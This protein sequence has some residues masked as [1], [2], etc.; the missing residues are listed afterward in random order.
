M[1]EHGF[2]FHSP[3][4]AH[5][6]INSSAMINELIAPFDS[7]MVV[8][9]K[10]AIVK[11]GFRHFIEENDDKNIIFFDSVEENPQINTIIK[12]AKE[13]RKNKCKAV[14]GFGGGSALDAAKA[15]AAFA[16]NNKSFYELFNR[17][18]LDNAPLETIL[19]PTTCGT[20]S[21]MNNYSI[22]TDIEKRDK[23]NF[24][25]ENTFAK[26]ALLDPALLRSLPEHILLATAFDAFT[27]AFEGFCSTRANPFSD[28]LAYTSMELLLSTLSTTDD[29]NSDMTL[30]NFMYASSLAG[31]VILHTGTTLLHA[32]GYYLTN[33]KKIHHGTAN[34]MLLPY[35]IRMLQEKGVARFAQLADVLRN[36]T[37]DLSGWLGRMNAKPL[38]EVMSEDE[39]RKMC[40]Y[41]LGKPN[42]GFTLFEADADFMMRILTDEKQGTF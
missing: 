12:G 2:N 26:H 40:E 3:V 10:T 34:A 24:A 6:G 33:E 27:H 28:M 25:K 7:V 21:E 39:L 4:K 30:Q 20:G 9:G 32:M 17:K 36:H 42:A 1:S 19:I 35:Y 11:T 13:A 15:I 5:F 8:S 37:L 14:I 22:I 16:T 38:K 23:L 29:L 18:K 31:V 41:A